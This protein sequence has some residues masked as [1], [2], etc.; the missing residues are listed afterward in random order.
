MDVPWESEIASRP[1]SSERIDMPSEAEIE[2]V[3]QTAWTDDWP[4]EDGVRIELRDGDPETTKRIF[5]FHS[6]G[7]LTL[8]TTGPRISPR[9]KG[10]IKDAKS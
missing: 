8:L 1:E 2:H 9:C 4:F 5:A 10:F 7:N 6:L 3:F